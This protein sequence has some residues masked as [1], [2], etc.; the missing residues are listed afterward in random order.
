MDCQMHAKD[1]LVGKDEKESGF[2]GENL[3][4]LRAAICMAQGL[5]QGLGRCEVLF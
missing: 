4:V 5:G 1:G 3:C 2:S